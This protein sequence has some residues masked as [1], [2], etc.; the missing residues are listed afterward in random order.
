M[1]ARSVDYSSIVTNVVALHSM[2]SHPSIGYL[3]L[4]STR[5]WELFTAALTRVCGTLTVLE[6]ET[7]DLPNPETCRFFPK[8]PRSY[9]VWYNLGL[10]VVIWEPLLGPCHIV[11]T[12]M[13][14]GLNS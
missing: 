4:T 7:T 2:Y 3:K 11:Y 10:K 6:P 8:S 5:Y 13:S 12:Y 1:D 9:M 14:Y